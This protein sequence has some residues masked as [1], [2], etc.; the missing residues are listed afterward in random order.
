M[1]KVRAPGG[2]R[3]VSCQMMSGFF[4]RRFAFFLVAF[5]LLAFFFLAFFLAMRSPFFPHCSGVTDD[6]IALL[7]D[8]EAV[9]SHD[10]LRFGAGASHAADGSTRARL[11]GPEGNDDPF[12]G[13]AADV[14]DHLEEALGHLG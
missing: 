10:G 2:A 13:R 3:T 6:E 9:R 4:F 8:A 12:T 5:F 1:R 7:R 11:E 14:S